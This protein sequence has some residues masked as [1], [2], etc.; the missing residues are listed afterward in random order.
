MLLPGPPTPF[1]ILV[2]SFESVLPR[3]FDWYISRRP[4]IVVP[5]PIDL[6]EHISSLVGQ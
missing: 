3:R 4:G 1:F 2:S 5:A 6:D